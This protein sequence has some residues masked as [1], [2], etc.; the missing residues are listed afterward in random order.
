MPEAIQ[1]ACQVRTQSITLMALLV[2]FSAAL[3]L[4]PT[5]PGT[6]ALKFN[7]FPIVLSGFLLGPVGGFWTG[8]LADV[9]SYIMKPGGPFIPV[10]TLTSGLAGMLPALL[11]RT[12]TRR[13]A[14]GHLPL[15]PWHLL[16]AIGISQML[17]KAVLVAG[18]RALV[19]GLPWQALALQALAEQA[20]HAPLYAYAIWVILGRL[21]D[22]FC[23]EERRNRLVRG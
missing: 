20:F 16:F 3:Q 15:K 7:G 22:N 11:Y 9:M 13:D 17:T 14:A 21:G 4:M 5:L 6:Y 19:F 23:L 12:I 10:F 8:A 2:A 1:N 18:C